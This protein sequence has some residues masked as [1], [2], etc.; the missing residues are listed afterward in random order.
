MI[1]VVVFH[2]FDKCLPFDKGL[3]DLNFLWR[4]VVRGFFSNVFYFYKGCIRLLNQQLHHAYYKMPFS[5][6]SI[7]FFFFLPIHRYSISKRS[8]NYQQYIRNLI[9]NDFCQTFAP[10]I[11]VI[12]FFYRFEKRCT[13]F[14]NK[15]NMYKVLKLKGYHQLDIKAWKKNQRRKKI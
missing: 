10:I 9:M 12:V 11:L 5:K 3:S 8:V 7:R 15:Y 14:C 6:F 1:L 13:S 2:S 4:S